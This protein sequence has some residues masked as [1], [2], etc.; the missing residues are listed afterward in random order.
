MIRE[1][2]ESG[3]SCTLKQ[4]KKNFREA[5]K[6]RTEKRPL[7]WAIRKTFREPNAVGFRIR[8]A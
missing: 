7:V 2:E 5:G 6:T 4:K 8:Q 1:V 3:K